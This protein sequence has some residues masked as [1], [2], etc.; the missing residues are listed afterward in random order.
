VLCPIV[1]LLIGAC[2]SGN[3]TDNAPL[4]NAAQ[5][6]PVD[7]RGSGE[8]YTAVV[9]AGSTGSR[10]YLYKATPGDGF[11]T[12]QSL[13]SYSS[14]SIPGLS[15]FSGNPADAGPK[16]IQPLLDN[17]SQYL[18]Q[19]QLQKN[20]V[21][22]SVLGTAGMRNVDSGTA[23]AI[24]NSVKQS[25]GGSDYTA[26]DVGTISG[27]N[28]GLYSWA[29]VNYLKHTFQN[30][31]PSYG[32]VE[33]GGSSAQVAYV[34]SAR[35]NPNVVMK[36][37]NGVTYPIFSISYLGLGQ[38]SACAA[39]IADSASG[40]DATPNACYT[41]GYSF[42]ANAGD[43]N[44]APGVKSLTGSYD[45]ATC[46]GIYRSVIKGFDVNHTAFAE[47]FDAARFLLV[48][49]SVSGVLGNW[50]LSPSDAS[51]TEL[52]TQ[53]QK[54]CEHAM[55]S[56]FLAAYS[57]YAPQRYLQPQCA[58]STYLG[59]FLYDRAGLHLQDGQ[60]VSVPNVDGVATTWTLGYV[61]LT[62]LSR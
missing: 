32:L 13:L 19:N 43:P 42:G 28:E 47:G 54:H 39:M 46:Q 3:Q 5:T 45:Y 40:G 26:A 11:G 56:D 50:G 62:Q 34:T 21:R 48:G 10:I 22:V 2:G 59:T 55:W 18:A 52:A 1:A 9:D 61:L 16:G 25:I 15:S 20:Q 6:S 14:S 31:T 33:V 51:P 36:T 30:H 8:I 27:Q 49:G 57:A 17:L 58:N 23:G 37:I 35:D 53:A 38:D 24:Y 4:A 29:D 7:N 12:I 41:A 60:A 44:P